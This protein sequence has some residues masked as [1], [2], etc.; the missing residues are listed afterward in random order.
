MLMPP[1]D[2]PVH[3]MPLPIVAHQRDRYYV[4]EVDGRRVMRQCNVYYEDF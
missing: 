2:S 1:P 3:C 4:E